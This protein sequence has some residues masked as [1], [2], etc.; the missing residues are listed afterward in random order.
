MPSYFFNVVGIFLS[1]RRQGLLTFD[2]LPFGIKN[3][4]VMMAHLLQ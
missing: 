4:V 1:K 2:Y 3:W